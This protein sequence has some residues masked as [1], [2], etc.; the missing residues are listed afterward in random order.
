MDPENDSVQVQRPGSGR[1]WIFIV[2]GGTVL[3]LLLMSSLLLAQTY[4]KPQPSAA[5]GVKHVPTTTDKSSVE[6]VRQ[7]VPPTLSPVATEVQSTETAINSQPAAPV[8]GS[9]ASAPEEHYYNLPEPS[10]MPVRRVAVAEAIAEALQKNL[11]VKIKEIDKSI[12]GDLIRQADGQFNPTFKVEGS[13]EDINRPQ[14]TQDFIS[15]GGTLLNLSR[16]PRIYKENNY[17]AKASLE[18]QLPIGTK[19]ELFSTLDVYK[20]TLNT[21]SPLSLFAPEWQSFSGVNLTQPL[22]K[23]FGTDVNLAQVRVA[24]AN[25]QISDLEFRSQVLETVASV[26]Q[27]YYDI[28]YLSEDFRLKQ[29]ECQLARRLTEEKRRLLEKGQATARDLNRAETV[30]AQTIEEM[31][32]SENKLLER[33]TQLLALMAN[34]DPAS[35][36]VLL[37]P[38]SEMPVGLPV[39]DVPGLINEALTHRP[40]YIAAKYKVERENVKLIYAEN[41]LWPQLD[42]KGTAGYNGLGAG[43]TRSY[44]LAFGG[45]GPQWSAGFVFS[46]PLGN[47]TAIGTR[48]EARKRK[49]EALLMLEQVENNTTL[50]VQQFAAVVHSNLQRLDAMRLFHRNAEKALDDE[51]IRLEKGLTTDLELLKFKRDLT[52]ARTREMAARADVNKV[53]VRLYQITGTLLDREKIVIGD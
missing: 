35:Q 17:H 3:V 51:E 28:T 39:L 50:G 52:D 26:L 36:P 32:Q 14:N 2:A 43:I 30:L 33:Q 18:G 53:L 7:D 49:E 22:W 29:E 12:G 38:T 9:K 40:E 15:T 48:D 45:Q 5:Q 27:A 42:F 24:R 46:I 4:H 47:D 16:D 8:A 19:Y 1:S 34:V 44:D 13:Y 31:T 37:E 23:G 20:N 6:Q 25:K 21:T 11:D 10:P 41:Q